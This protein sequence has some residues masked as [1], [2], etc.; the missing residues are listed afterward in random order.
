MAKQND[1]NV[2]KATVG[3]S[4]GSLPKDFSASIPVEMD[5]SGATREE[6]VEWA[7]YGR[8]VSL[9]RV[10]RTK[11]PEYLKGLQNDGLKIH[12]RYAGHDIKTRDEMI[13]DLVAQGV[14]E[15][16][17]VIV[18][19]NPERAR[20]MAEEANLANKAVDAQKES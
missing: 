18:I 13:A 9:Q 8:K 1:S 15:T 14:P 11:S 7:M 20:K 19:D 12:A 5:F 6:L 3:V 17:A 16:Y 10:L 2:V 4:G